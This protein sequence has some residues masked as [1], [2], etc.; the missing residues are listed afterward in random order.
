MKQAISP[1]GESRSDFESVC[2]VAS[3]LGK[4]TAVTEE[5]TVEELEKIVFNSL[6]IDDGIGWE[7]FKEKGY[8][9]IPVAKD[10][11]KD[12]AG[13]F[14]F[15]QDPEANPLPTPTGKLEF[16]SESIAKNFPTDTERPPIPKWIEKSETHDERLSSQRALDYPLL[17]MSNHGR[18][19]VHA[20]CDDISWTREAITAKVK[21]WDG[22]MYEPCWMNPADAE[23]RDIKNGDIIR[24]CNERGSVLCGALVWERIMPNVI[25]I[26][27]GARVDYIIPGKLDRGGAINTIA[28]QGLVSKHCAGQATSGFLAEVE[29][30]DQKQMEE[31]KT[32]YP[33]AFNREY[34]A[35]SGLRFNAWI[36]EGNE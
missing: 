20:Q 31:W 36:I 14:K 27:H 18:W 32:L 12:P 2:E 23:K 3:K 34:D 25:S 26:D 6:S 17:I 9:V 24:V 22:Y 19:R 28:P 15:Y 4:L 33:D 10:W 30:V 13:L 11:E 8:Y 5:K 21:G 7:E 35:A 16:Y 29:K 1:I